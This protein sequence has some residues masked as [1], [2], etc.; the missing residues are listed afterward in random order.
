MRKQGECIAGK[1][2]RF[3]RDLQKKFI[4]NIKNESGISWK[5]LA[6]DI[7]VSSYTL[8]VAWGKEKTT[9]PYTIVKDLLSRYEF[10]KFDKIKE[11]WVEGI[12]TDNWGQRRGGKNSGNVGQRKKI[13]MPKYSEEYAELIGTIL[14]DGYLGKKELT[15]TGADHEK[16]YIYY[17][18]KQIQKLFGLR[19]KL[20]NNYSNKN[21]VV[22][23]CYSKELIEL[24]SIDGL[25]IGNKIKNGAR[26]PKWI[27]RKNAYVRC[28]LRGLF[29]TDGGIY[30]KQ[31]GYRR[32]VIEFQTA[33]PEIR[34]EILYFL[35]KI[36]YSPSKSATSN[37]K[38]KR[39]NV[40]I[41]N[42]D[43]ILRFFRLIGSSNPK[44]IIRY[45]HFLKNGI[46]PRKEEMYDEIIN[47]KGKIPYKSRP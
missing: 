32:A 35:K 43:E 3:R 46:I 9:I 7:G 27:S 45:K 17:I 8:R 19:S 10:E 41:Q 11:E 29:D 6:Q 24:L 42:Q 25:V 23:D 34:E 4:D 16:R 36:G 37:G 1:R 15:I 2:F 5:M 39:Y 14:G 22:L 13:V 33:S 12:L 28:A 26:F 47:Y 20:F 44:N 21:A 40:R 38:S 18:K 30:S 31:K